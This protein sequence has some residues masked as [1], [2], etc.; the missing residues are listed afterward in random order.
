MGEKQKLSYEQLEE[1]AQQM[2]EQLKKVYQQLQEASMGNLFKRLDFLFKVL[3]NAHMFDDTFVDTCTNEVVKL[4]TLPEDKEDSL[5]EEEP[6]P[7]ELDTTA[8]V[9]EAEAVAETKAAK[10]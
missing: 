7:S 8:E 6:H 5:V 9:D 1:V 10:K 3:E 2:N 4:I